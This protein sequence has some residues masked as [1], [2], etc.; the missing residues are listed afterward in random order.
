MGGIE[1][2]ETA[3]IL[4]QRG[5]WLPQI[6]SQGLSLLHASGLVVVG[7]RWYNPEDPTDLQKLHQH[8]P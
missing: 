5:R 7:N 6:Q 2:N 8:I 4:R 3:S 1:G